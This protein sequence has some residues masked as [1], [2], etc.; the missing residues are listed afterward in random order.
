[1]SYK[2]TITTLTALAFLTIAGC[3]ETAA[4]KENG[5]L[6][7]SEQ[8]KSS[9]VFLSISAAP[10]VQVQPWKYSDIAQRIG[11][12]IAVGPYQV[13]TP[14]KNIV[15][16]RLIKARVFGQNEYIPTKIKLI[17][18][19]TNLCLIELD[20]NAMA[21]PL[22]PVEFIADYS[23]GEELTYYWLPASGNLATGRGYLSKAEVQ[24]SQTSYASYMQFVLS[25]TSKQTSIGQI[26][27]NGKKAIGIACWTN[28]KGEAGLIPSATINRFL[29]SA[30]QPQYASIPVG[31]FAISPLLDPAIRKYLK[32]PEDLTHG[33]YIEKVFNLGTA[34]DI[35]QKDDCL[36]AIDGNQ[37][38]AYGR[39]V[40]PQFEQTS[41]RHLIAGKNIGEQIAFTV[42]R[43]GK[44]IQ[45]QAVAKT[46][47]ADK[48]LIPFYEYD[49]QPQY[50][51]VAGFIFQKLSRDYFAMW[52]NDFA[53]KVGPHIYNYYRNDAYKPTDKR[54]DIVILSYVLPADINLG[55]QKLAQLVVKTVNSQEITGIKDM[56][57][58]LAIENDSKFHVIEFEMDQPTLV[59]PKDELQAADMKIAQTY[60]ITQL[61][62]IE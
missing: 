33:V 54:R 60:G 27:F 41:Y 5:R 57:Q 1:M 48:M 62:H 34:S 24:G 42:W 18:Y 21:T 59:I 37:I 6:D 12:G 20:K 2:A 40:H 26:F 16:A 13:I 38:D 58:A 46:F 29:K 39:F 4:V 51:I 32:M 52:G 19:E 8:M 22:V 3:T 11:A 31:G 43:D 28:D 35:L 10:Y 50:M 47:K 9:A 14:A 25:N 7:L 23:K 45:L 15:D 56:Q 44:E 30:Q 55:Y 53:G 36:L 61:A 49:K 17:D